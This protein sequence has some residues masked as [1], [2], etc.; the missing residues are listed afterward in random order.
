MP[1]GCRKDF[2]MPEVT[3][4]PD[5]HIPFAGYTIPYYEQAV[6]MVIRA[7]HLHKGL[8]GVGWDVAITENG[9][10]MIEANPFF[11]FGIMQATTHGYR[12]LLWQSYLP[13]ALKFAP[14]YDVLL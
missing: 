9:P 10:L 14:L 3:E 4:H 11:D 13:Q 1:H 5:S 2:S 12:K 8:N 7:H 6:D